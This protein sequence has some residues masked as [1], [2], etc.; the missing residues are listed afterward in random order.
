M[1]TTEKNHRELMPFLNKDFESR[2]E[3]KPFFSSLEKDPRPGV[4]DF[5]VPWHRGAYDYCD[6]QYIIIRHAGKQNIASWKWS[7]YS[8]YSIRLVSDIWFD[9]IYM[10]Q[11]L[12]GTCET[13][14]YGHWE[15]D[16]NKGRFHSTT[17][18]LVKVRKG[19]KYGFIR[20]SHDKNRPFLSDGAAFDS[21]NGKWTWNPDAGQNIIDVTV[22]GTEMFFGSK[23]V[24]FPKNRNM[25]KELEDARRT[26]VNK[27]DILKGWIDKD[28]PCAR[29]C[30]F[31][32]KGAGT[33]KISKEEAKA[34]LPGYGFGRG[35]YEIRFE[36]IGEPTLV[37]IEY[38][39]SDMF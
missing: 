31:A 34:L 1:N 16:Y 29:R 3:L 6:T 32:W 25:K 36:M 11:A 39:E 23:G 26:F 35:F 8:G 13:Q 19:R 28:K 17:E 12:M 27:D 38:S 22:N 37:F 7:Q 15:R 9:R 2:S 30:G 21:V 14:A 20:L 33:R 5:S 24:M 10:E 4:N 18:S